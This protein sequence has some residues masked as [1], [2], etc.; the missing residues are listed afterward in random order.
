MIVAVS[1]AAL[2]ATSAYFSD[3]ETSTGNTFTAGA[4]DLLIDNDAWYNGQRVP[5]MSW[6]LTNLTIQKFFNL[7]D[8]KPGDWEEDTISLH[9]NDNDAWMCMDLVLTSDDDATSTE[10]ELGDG[11]L[12]EN[13]LDM[14]DGELAQSMQSIWWADDGD[15]VLEEGERIF[16]RGTLSDLASTSQRLADRNGNIWNPEGGPIIGAQTYYIG[17]AF[18]FG[19]LTPT[20]I[21]NNG[22]VNPGV[23]TGFTCNGTLLDNITQTDTLTADLRFFAVQSRNNPNFEC[24]PGNIGCLGKADVMIVM[25]RSG[26]IDNTELGQLQTAANAFVDALNPTAD[27]VHVG[28]VSFSTNAT[29]NEHLTSDGNAV[30]TDINNLTAG[31]TTN[32]YEALSLANDELD[33]TTTD[34]FSGFDRP[35]GDSPDVIVVLTDGNPNVPNGEAY[36]SAVAAAEALVGKNSGVQ[37]YVVGVGVDV[38]ATYLTNS[39]ASSNAHY[40]SSANFGDLS[41]ILSGIASCN[42]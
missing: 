21:A 30:K 1:S 19:T 31:G 5:E 39:I 9:V 4:V 8:V 24:T 36:A 22:G 6:E 27:G 7:L 11:D 15:N 37:I 25:D 40:F 2:G 23:A 42:Q 38:D 28:L 3:V 16:M 20:P 29:L 10:P 26:S 14:Y 33:A 32:L 13:P 18:C 17:K 34:A 41:A 12:L 35:D